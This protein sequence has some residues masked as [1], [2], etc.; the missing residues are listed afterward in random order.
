MGSAA[1]DGKFELEIK[2]EE[3]TR[4]PPVEKTE[5]GHY[6]LCNLDQNIAVIMRTIYLYKSP[7]KG[8]AD[9]AKIVRESLS[10]VLVHFYP[11][12][13]RLTMSPEGKLIVD[14]IGEGPLFVEAEANCSVLELVGIAGADPMVLKNLIYDVPGAKNIIETPIFTVQ[15]TKFSC[16]AF[17]VGLAMNHCMA[18][19]ISAVEFIN[20]WGEI[21][22]GLPLSTPP[23]LDRTILKARD[24][25]QIEFPQNEFLDIEDISYTHELYDEEMVH[26][27]FPFSPEKL[28]RLKEK[29]LESGALSKCTT[30]E[31]LT[32]LVWR[33]RCKAL[34]MHP[35]QQTKLLFAVDGRSKFD[36][37]LPKGFFGNGIVLT[38]ALC[39]AG[40]LLETPLSHAV[41]LVQGAVKL[42]TDSYMRSAIDY[43][44]LTR[45]RP[46]MNGTL[47][48]TA[49]SRLAFHSPNFGWGETIY[50]GPVGVPEKEVALFLPSGEDRRSINVHLGMPASAMKIFEEEIMRI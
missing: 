49:W 27:A 35:D 13:G 22:R 14:C 8:N 6:F 23:S 31:A 36:P 25:P 40:D 39:K 37:P 45:A 17:A 24:P 44:E 4:V 48:I 3:P 38:N 7:E 10:K 19:G 47:L 21:A 20:S 43:F 12:A 11:L 2:Q 15:V 26:R 32:A 28:G 9:A 42:V 16:G 5:K 30:F 29:A 18:D 34:R 46:S 33:A 41:E 50:T 1:C